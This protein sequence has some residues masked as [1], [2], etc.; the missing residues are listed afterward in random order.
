MSFVY[1]ILGE[2]FYYQNVPCVRFG[3]PGISWLTSFHKDSDYNHPPE[4]LNIN[5][6]ITNSYGTCALQIEQSP[7]S[8]YYVSL[9]QRPGEITFINHINCKHGA[10]I[11]KEDY[12]MISLD[13]RIIPESLAHAAFSNNLS[14]LT[15][16]PF[17][18]GGY[19]SANAFRD[20]Q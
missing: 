9:N 17:R 4:E 3:L 15:K 12:T 20:N 14:V 1:P 5:L 6:A 19:F 18:P 11:N 13:F 7:G 2:G 16:V 10:I 8:T